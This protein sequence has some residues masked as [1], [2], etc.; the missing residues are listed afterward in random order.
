MLVAVP[1]AH[2]P[3]AFAHAR[4][5]HSYLVHDRGLLMSSIFSA[6]Y[7]CLPHYPSATIWERRR[8]KKTNILKMLIFVLKIVELL[9]SYVV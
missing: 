8:N 9:Y 1:C 6:F 2:G 3:V 7:L 4:C 5:A